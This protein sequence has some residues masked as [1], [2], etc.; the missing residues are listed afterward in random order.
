MGLVNGPKPKEDPVHKDTGLRDLPSYPFRECRL[1]P[2][3]EQFVAE[4]I[5]PDLKLTGYKLDQKKILA[6]QIIH[7]LIGKGAKGCCVADRRNRGEPGV[8]ARVPIWDR[9]V[10]LGYVRVCIGSEMSGKVTRYRATSKL[11]D[12][13]KK[14]SLSQFDNTTL[15]RIS[16]MNEPTP[17]DLIQLLSTVQLRMGTQ[18]ASTLRQCQSNRTTHEN[19]GDSNF[20][21]TLPLMVA[22]G[23]QPI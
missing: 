21:A 13:R 12:L 19:N 10:E 5:L 6:T 16:K 22:G 15:E 23:R 9:L 20:V 8:K 3:F 7:N 17:Y 11:L 2:V 18:W 1:I 14:W 4:R